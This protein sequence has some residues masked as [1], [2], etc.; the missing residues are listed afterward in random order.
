MKFEIGKW[1]LETGRSSAV[2]NPRRGLPTFGKR[3]YA[4]AKLGGETNDWFSGDLTADQAIYGGMRRMRNRARDLARN[5]DYTRRFL[6]LAKTNIVG[7]R[8]IQFR[9]KTV[10]Y[11]KNKEILSV[12]D[13]AVLNRAFSAWSKPGSCTVDRRMSFRD[14]QDMLVE[15]WLVDGEFIARKI[16]GYDNEYGFALQPIDADRLD[17]QLN[18]QRSATQNEIRMGV[19]IDQ[20]NAPVAYWFI[21]GDAP[22]NS[23]GY[24]RHAHTRIPAAEIE[25]VYQ[26]ERPGQTRGVTYLAPIA[27]RKKML[28]GFMNA[29]VVGS[30]VAASQMG[31]FIANPDNP[32]PEETGEEEN[33]DGSIKRNAE[34]GM[35]EELPPW[36][37]DFKPFD[38]GYPPANF[39]EFCKSIVRGISSGL[40][41]SYIAGANDLQGVSYSAGRIAMLADQDLWRTMQTFVIEHFC[42]LIYPDWLVMAITVQAVSLPMSKLA[43]FKAHTWRP[44]GWEW[45]DPDKQGKAAARDIDYGIQSRR[46]I[47]E[48]RGIDIDEVFRELAEERKKMEELG[49]PIVSGTSVANE[50][51]EPAQPDPENDGE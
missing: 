38:P 35:L 22:P 48:Q 23:M 15:C 47:A 46:M 17:E 19:E 42:E 39:D 27:L 1:K 16:R 8:G 44:R 7:H 14:V 4:M 20:W 26:M 2:K 9:A 36:I 28:D 24:Y 10:D 25:H 12:Y 18:R 51:P 40:G 32:R 6:H 41:I 50:P 30:R 5:D 11:V 29:V 31:F 49:I 33:P 3:H 13:N 37:S 21:D 43:K 45:T 34:P